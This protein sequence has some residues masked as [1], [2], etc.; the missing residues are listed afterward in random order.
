MPDVGRY[1][2]KE[3]N[4][5]FIFNVYVSALDEMEEAVVESYIGT[6]EMIWSDVFNFPE[7]LI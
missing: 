4:L 2:E 5:R 6:N 3:L 7:H 1:V